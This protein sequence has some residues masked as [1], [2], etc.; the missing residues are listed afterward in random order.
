MWLSS[1]FV[2]QAP[3]CSLVWLSSQG[4]GF[5][6]PP[7]LVFCSF[8]PDN[9]V[10][11][12]SP[13]LLFLPFVCLP[14]CSCVPFAPLP[15]LFV[16]FN[17]SPLIIYSLWTWYPWAKSLQGARWSEVGV[18]CCDLQTQGFHGLSGLE[19]PVWIKQPPTQTRKYYF[20]IKYNYSYI[21]TY[22]TI[23]IR[24]HELWLTRDQHSW[25]PKI[26]LII[27][28]NVNLIICFYQ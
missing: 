3:Q 10:S 1:L 12:P 17:H 21:S 15:H 16:H 4:K 13:T 14:P 26:R 8:P 19:T 20:Y 25:Q 22:I 18:G 24:K 23:I 5:F 27:C 7:L 28:K 6:F 9:G 11:L 2:L